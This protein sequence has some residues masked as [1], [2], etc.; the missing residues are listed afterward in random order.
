MGLKNSR[1]GP[2]H[3]GKI[4]YPIKMIGNDIEFLLPGAVEPGGGS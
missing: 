3:G 4:I 1:T 2:L